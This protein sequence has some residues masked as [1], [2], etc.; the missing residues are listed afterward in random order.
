[1]RSSLLFSI[2]LLFVLSVC[3]GTVSNAPNPY[4]NTKG[5][6]LVICSNDDKKQFSNLFSILT[7][8]W[9]YKLTYFTENTP[10]SYLPA[11]WD[12][13]FDHLFIF[14]S[15]AAS[16]PSILSSSKLTQFF[17]HGHN[18]MVF[19]DAERNAL[20]AS[21]VREFLLEKGFLFPEITKSK[22]LTAFTAP[23]E[24]KEFFFKI[25]QIF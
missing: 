13:K 6:V 3:Y 10:V 4:I 5:T 22:A 21:E 11:D 25:L 12:S 20:F 2:V 15:A 1:M 24:K 14:G 23:T 19:T 8:K 17:D 16:Y 18:I 9:Q 7:E